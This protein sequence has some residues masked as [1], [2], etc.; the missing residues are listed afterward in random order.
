MGF[1]SVKISFGPVHLSKK[2]WSLYY[3][4]AF[5]LALRAVAV[6]YPFRVAQA[7]NINRANLALFSSLLVLRSTSDLYNIPCYKVYKCPCKIK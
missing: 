1:L 2:R 5:C 4:R 6:R 7:L 3:R